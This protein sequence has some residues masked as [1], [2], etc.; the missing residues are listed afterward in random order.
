MNLVDLRIFVSAAS[1]P[2]L[3][4]AALEMHLTPSAVSKALR[5][6]EENLGTP[7]FDRSAK[8]LVLNDAGRRLLG[9]AQHLLALADQARCDV[10][11]ERA[12]VDCRLG[13]PPILLWRHGDGVA[14]ALNAYP[15][16]TVRLTTMFEDEALA[17]LARGDINVAIVT[18]AAIEGRGQHW[19]P[20]WE[21]TPLGALSLHLVAHR[22]HPLVRQATKGAV[23]AEAVLQHDFASPTRSMFCG[24]QRGSHSDGWR[25]DRLPR[26]IRYWTDDLHLLVGFVNSGA[27]LAY[28]PD[29]A[30]EEPDLVKIDVKDSS[31]ECNE[32]V[33]LVWNRVNAG[34]WQKRLAGE[35]SHADSDGKI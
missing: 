24:E 6:L 35:L 14:Q 2:S 9:R 10:M 31:F 3:A 20:E 28:L 27:A 29:F 25:D 12:Q 13:G 26:R 16:A 4:A 1:R 8:L 5:R 33:W 17:A 7:L 18:G 32:H 11:G 30:A 22:N 23:L 15:E 21:A 34:E 19:S